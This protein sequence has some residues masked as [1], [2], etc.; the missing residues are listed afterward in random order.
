MTITTQKIADKNTFFGELKNILAA[1]EQDRKDIYFD[2]AG[3]ATTG[4]GFNLRSAE[5]VKDLKRRT[6][7]K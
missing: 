5:T 3:N 6:F 1:I 7:S 4:I 2:G